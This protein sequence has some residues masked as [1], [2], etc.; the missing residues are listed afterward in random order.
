MKY[1]R[2]LLEQVAS[3][4]A[5]AISKH[6]AGLEEPEQAYDT[7]FGVVPEEIRPFFVLREQKNDEAIAI[8]EAGQMM[9]DEDRLNNT[10][11][12]LTYVKMF[13]KIAALS[14]EAELLGDMAWASLRDAF[15]EELGEKP[16]FGI[17]KDWA[18]V[19]V[20]EEERN[21]RIIGGAVADFLLDNMP[22]GQSKH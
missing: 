6:G 7:V 14:R 4:T 10:D 12:S 5:E 20:D 22:V 21:S 17:R 15:P 11:R 19:V 1:I 3:I 13:L 9:C 18:I 2:S 16:V 8:S